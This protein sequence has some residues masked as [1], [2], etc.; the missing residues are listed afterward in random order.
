MDY[1]INQIFQTIQGEGY[2]TG[3]AAIFIRLQGLSSRV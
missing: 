1:P 2:F 3:V